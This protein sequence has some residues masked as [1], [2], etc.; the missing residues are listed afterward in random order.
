MAISSRPPWASGSLMCTETYT[1]TYFRMKAPE[2]NEAAAIQERN[3]GTHVEM[4]FSGMDVG[5]GCA[6]RG[7]EKVRVHGPW[8]GPVVPRECHPRDPMMYWFE[9]N[10]DLGST[11]D[12]E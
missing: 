7:T 11:P 1:S 12:A 9:H 8:T 2:I 3:H 6:E 4:T 5:L 10:E